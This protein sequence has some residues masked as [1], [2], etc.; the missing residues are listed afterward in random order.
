M[1]YVYDY[2]K[3]VNVAR[4]SSYIY[5]G[6][7]RLCAR[8]LT[9]KGPYRVSSYFSTTAGNCTALFNRATLSA[10]VVAVAAN[11]Y[12][13]MYYKS[14]ILSLSNCPANSVDHAVLVVGYDA[15]SNWK[16][17]NSWGTSWGISGYAYLA[18]NNACNIC[19][20]GGYY[21]TLV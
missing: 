16:I 17:Q 1:S 7:Q 13:F 10:V 3:A 8:P 20:W 6:T 15:N 4:E 12:A 14:G 18:A 19:A 5:N 21:S 11:T 2:A 9:A